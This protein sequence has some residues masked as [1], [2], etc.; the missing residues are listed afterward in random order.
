MHCPVLIMWISKTL[1]NGF[2]I[3]LQVLLAVLL[4][5]VLYTA[6]IVSLMS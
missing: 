4:S 2:H 3:G 1:P 5:E 6:V